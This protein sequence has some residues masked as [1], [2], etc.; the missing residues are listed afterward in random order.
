LNKPFEL[1]PIF[2]ERVWGKTSLA[3]F[4]T[5]QSR[6]PNRPDNASIG[7][8][9]FSFS[10]NPTIFGKKLED[11]LK[12]HPEYLGTGADPDHP[13]LC[14]ILVKFLFTKERLS[15]QVHPDDQHAK[16][17]HGSL[18]KTEAWYVLD[19]EPPGEIAAGFREELTE[20][21]FKDAVASGEIEHL[22]DW[23]QVSPGDVIFV[24][25]GTVHAI[26]AGLTICEI[27][28]NSDITYRLYDYGRGRELHL[29]H[30]MNVSHLGPHKASA[31]PAALADGR[32]ELASSD[33][34]RIE[35]LKPKESISLDGS[36]SHYSI[37]THL[38]GAGTIE[39]KP[40][41]P[42]QTYFV[43]AASSCAVQA[44]GSEWI[45]TYKHPRPA[46]IQMK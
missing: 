44:P 24:P 34:F 14:P 4:F 45:I 20:D 21:R 6:L 7:E 38:K 3:P 41:S 12:E 19:A 35:R 30:G 28:Q 18:G 43:P 10:E 33:H 29:E 46:A 37:L 22:L 36:H 8:V 26:G 25:A 2:R 39:G 31:P 27:Q 9:W 42:G 23:R 5:D 16:T 1:L 32:E 17:H 15:V 11:V 13:G 40:T